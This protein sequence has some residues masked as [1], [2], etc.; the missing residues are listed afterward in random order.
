LKKHASIANFDVGV[1]S[2]KDQT[3]WRNPAVYAAQAP[4]AVAAETVL[5]FSDFADTF[6]LVLE[7]IL[8][9]RG[10]PDLE[11]IDRVLESAYERVI[12]S[13][14]TSIKEMGCIVRDEL[15]GR[16]G[17]GRV[18]TFSG[19]GSRSHSEEQVQYL[20]QLLLALPENLQAVFRDY[21]TGGLTEQ[22]ASA[23][24]GI[25]YQE[26]SSTRASLKMRVGI[27][28]IA[29]SHFSATA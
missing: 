25:S 22:T 11:V 6:R 14:Q 21:Y 8:Q 20:R 17:K 2:D 13:R 24:H 7:L 3:P 15:N 27:R 23:K 12:A 5:H 9:T 18:S 29:A 19:P 1:T 16:V 10:C 26:F 28:T 4:L